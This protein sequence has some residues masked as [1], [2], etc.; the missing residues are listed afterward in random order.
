MA[1]PYKGSNEEQRQLNMLSWLTTEKRKKDE[2]GF[3]D[4][5]VLS[6]ALKDMSFGPPRGGKR[7]LLSGEAGT[8]MGTAKLYRH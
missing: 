6:R 5:L 1:L 2:C 8:E 7:T 4:V 3:V